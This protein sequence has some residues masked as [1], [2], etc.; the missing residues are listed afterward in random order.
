MHSM[1]FVIGDDPIGQVTATA[2]HKE[3]KRTEFEAVA[4]D[5]L[6]PNIGIDWVAI[7]GRYSGFLIPQAGAQG[8]VYGD[9]VPAVEA[10]LASYMPPGAVF[11]RPGARGDRSGVDQIRASDVDWDATHDSAGG[12]WPAVLVAHGE[13][14]DARA[15][16]TSEESA[17]CMVPPEAVLPEHQAEVEAWRAAAAGKL[18]RWNRDVLI[19]ALEAAADAGDLVTVVNIHE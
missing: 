9:A 5:R 17:A 7:G 15:G 4:H 6:G 3:W 13:W 14:H 11:T 16:L 8:K 2:S 12:R 18:G 1:I 10:H 19:P